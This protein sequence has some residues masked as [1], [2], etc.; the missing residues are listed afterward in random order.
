M[1]LR[2]K[3]FE[4]M[5]DEQTYTSIQARINDAEGTVLFNYDGKWYTRVLHKVGLYTG[6]YYRGW[7]FK[8]ETAEFERGWL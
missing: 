2:E 1:K 8:I 6:F 7:F 5:T 3:I 4:A